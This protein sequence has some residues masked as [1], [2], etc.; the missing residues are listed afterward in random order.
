MKSITLR[1]DMILCGVNEFLEF[2]SRREG[3]TLG[4]YTLDF[5]I[6]KKKCIALGRIR[7]YDPPLTLRTL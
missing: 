5:Y 4:N 2:V 1:A 6:R 3:L 7:T